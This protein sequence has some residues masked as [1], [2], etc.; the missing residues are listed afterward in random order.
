MSRRGNC[1]DNAVAESFFNLIKGELVRRRLYKTRDEARKDIFDYIKMFYNL[2]RKHGRN[3][4]MSPIDYG[5]Q[6]K[7]RS[8]GV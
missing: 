4:M 1:H 8:E 3:G 5:R 7:I 2:K 6:Q